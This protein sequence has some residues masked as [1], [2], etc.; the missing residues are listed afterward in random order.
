M[1]FSYLAGDQK[2]FSNGSKI[3]VYMVSN[4]DPSNWTLVKTIDWTTLEAAR[5]RDFCPMHLKFDKKYLTDL[6]I[7]SNCAFT[8]SYHSGAKIYSIDVENSTVSSLRP[9]VDIDLAPGTEITGRIGFCPFDE[10]YIVYALDQNIVIMTSKRPTLSHYTIPLSDFGYTST[11]DFHCMSNIGMYGVRGQQADNKFV[12][13]LY[14]GNVGFN[15]GKFVNQIW[16]DLDPA[17]FSDTMSYGLDWQVLTVDFAVDETGAHTAGAVYQTLVEPPMIFTTT[18]DLADQQRY[19]EKGTMTITA[20]A[21][22]FKKDLVADI[23]TVKQ[24]FTIRPVNKEGWNPRQ[25]TIFVEDYCQLTG[26]ITDITITPNKG[27]DITFADRKRFEGTMAITDNKIVFAEYRGSIEHGFGLTPKPESDQTTFSLVDNGVIT[28]QFDLPRV[29]AADSTAFLQQ[30]DSRLVVACMATSNGEAVQ[31][32]S[33]DDSG[34][35]IMLSSRNTGTRADKIR[36]NKFMGKYIAFGLDA[37]TGVLTTWEIRN[38]DNDLVFYVIDQTTHVKDFD[39]ASSSTN[40]YNYF[41]RDHDSHVYQVQYSP[42]QG[43]IDVSD[44]VTILLD[45]N[46][47]WWL[48]SIAC[49]NNSANNGAICVVNTYGTVLIAFQQLFPE[50]LNGRVGEA[51]VTLQMYEKLAGFDGAMLFIDEEFIAHRVF[52]TKTGGTLTAYANIYSRSSS[53]QLHT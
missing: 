6:H 13:G 51:N 4:S 33:V 30:A 17:Q 27:S 31:A 43:G 36:V 41:I 44:A 23:W 1:A 5:S 15:N 21:P 32:F 46:R 18:G 24:D 37:S 22:L 28:H 20:T 14:W 52:N 7:L 11:V 19:F 45:R 39:P 40:L 47:P 12:Y 29:T 49:N 34:Q 42:V 16:S 9:T 53:N 10:N 50:A 25:G 35:S 26:P 38:E 48:Q 3:E 8:Q 2:T